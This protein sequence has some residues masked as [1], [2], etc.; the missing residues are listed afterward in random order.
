MGKKFFVLLIICILVAGKVDV[1]AVTYAYSIGTK[2]S[3]TVDYT[4]NVAGAMGAY[5]GMNN[6]LSYSSFKPTAS[7]IRSNNPNGNRI[8]AS[9]IVFL[10]GHANFQRIYFNHMNNSTYMTGICTGND[11]SDEGYTFAGLNSTDMSTCKLITFAG[12][13]TGYL[14]SDYKCLA[15]KAVARG[16]KTAVGWRQTIY[17][18]YTEGKNWLYI[19]NDSISDGMSVSASI[20]AA[21]NAYPTDEMTTYV[22]IAGSPTTA[23]ATASLV[24]GPSVELENMENLEAT[25]FNNTTILTALNEFDSTINL[26]D[27]KVSVNMFD[28]VNGDGFVVFTYYINGEIKTNKAYICHI[29]GNKLSYIVDS[30]EEGNGE[31]SVAS[32]DSISNSLTQKE[33]VSKVNAHKNSKV[34]KASSENLVTLEEY[35]EVYFYDYKTNKLTYREYSAHNDTKLNVIIPQ[36]TETEL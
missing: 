16:A 14:G 35:K 15:E 9:K 25:D 27:Y 7:F 22:Q 10:N 28:Q 5:I 11:K 12:C 31:V 19:Y 18:L 17:S 26:S 29:E 3:D 4:G 34:A 8:I 24:D 1:K 21:A 30:L 6:L 36:V 2:W 33:I 13:Y 20:R 32:A 23:F